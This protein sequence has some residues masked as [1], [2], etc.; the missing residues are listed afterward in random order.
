MLEAKSSSPCNEQ[1]LKDWRN[2]MAITKIGNSQRTAT[3]VADWTGL[4]TFG[5]VVFGNDYWFDSPM[6]IFELAVSFWLLFKCLKTG[7]YSEAACIS[8]GLSKSLSL[9]LPVFL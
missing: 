7:D 6:A 3:K 9:R 4:L 2:E 8:R 1:I 5:I